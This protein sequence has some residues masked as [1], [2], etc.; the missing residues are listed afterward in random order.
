VNKGKGVN[1]SKKVQPE[2]I[3]MIKPPNSMA[4]LT[5]RNHSGNQFFFLLKEVKSCI[6]PMG[7]IQPQKT[8]P[9][10]AAAIIMMTAGMRDKK[11]TR[12]PVRIA[13][14]LIMGSSLHMSLMGDEG[15]VML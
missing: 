13:L 11:G 2:N 15:L 14:R 7:Q 6:N 10:K 3:G 9:K 5:N 1:H 8:L 12:V 4:Y